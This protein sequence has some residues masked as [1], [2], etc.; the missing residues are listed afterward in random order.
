[1]FSYAADVRERD[2][3]KRRKYKKLKVENTDELQQLLSSGCIDKRTKGKKCT[4]CQKVCLGYDMGRFPMDHESYTTYRLQFN[5]IYW[6]SLC[7]ACKFVNAKNRNA[8]RPASDIFMEYLV[9]GMA[10]HIDGTR[11]DMKDTF[12]Y[13]KKRDQGHCASCNILVISNFK[14][15]WKQ[16]SVNDRYPDTKQPNKKCQLEDLVICC[17]ACN[18]F[19]NSLP[20]DIHLNALSQIANVKTFSRNTNVLTDIERMWFYRDHGKNSKRCKNDVRQQLLQRDGRYCTVTGVELMFE[21][22]HWN[23]VSFDRIDSKLPYTLEN[24]RLVCKNINFVKKKHIT[25]SELQAWLAHIRIQFCS[26]TTNFI[27]AIY[28]TYFINGGSLSIM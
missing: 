20:W 16:E 25:E 7:T 23:T 4:S 10:R 11:A 5:M 9:G 3:E 26:D 2:R 27:D 12:Q 15:G 13:I 6:Q 18:S 17:S 28:D 22:H 24:V 21:S 14:S 1:M 19:Q 8:N